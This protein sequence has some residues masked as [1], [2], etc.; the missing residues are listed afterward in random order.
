MPFADEDSKNYLSMS[1]KVTNL[2][3][4]EESKFSK[5]PQDNKPKSILVFWLSF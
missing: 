2:K 3:N 5:F 1:K 4:I